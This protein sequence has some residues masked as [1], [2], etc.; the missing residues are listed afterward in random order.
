[1]YTICVQYHVYNM[2][3]IP[4]I[5]YVYNT[6]YTICVQY[7]VYNMCTIPC[8]HATPPSSHTCQPIHN[9]NPPTPTT[10]PPPPLKT[11]NQHT[12]G[13]AS[14]PVDTKII[15]SNHDYEKTPSYDEL[16]TRARNMRDAGADIVK[17]ACMA[18]V[19]VC[20]LGWGCFG[21]GCFLHYMYVV[22]NRHALSVYPYTQPS[23]QINSRNSNTY[24]HHL[25]VP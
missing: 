12:G 5:Q 9:L 21:W 22:R 18:N 10:P 14:L 7:H 15:I 24:T 2:C 20:F 8:V 11:Q 19:C 25:H 4:C 17:I 23:Q 3:T 1:M 16:C 13:G 6:M